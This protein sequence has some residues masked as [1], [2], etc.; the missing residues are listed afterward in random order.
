MQPEQIKTLA[1][2]QWRKPGVA[3]VDRPSGWVT[4]DEAPHLGG[5]YWKGEKDEL[6]RTQTKKLRKPR[7]R[8][9]STS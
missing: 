6:W 2:K 9:Q 8:A 7:K 4:P 5:G 1:E 3:A